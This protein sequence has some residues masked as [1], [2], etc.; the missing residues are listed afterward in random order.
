[1]DRLEVVDVVGSLCRNNDNCQT[2]ELPVTELELLLVIPTTLGPWIFQWAISTM[3]SCVRQKFCF[4]R[5]GQARLIRR[6][7]KPEDYLA[8]LY[9]FD[10]EK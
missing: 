3:P 7:E 9:G 4:K 10:I 5:D 2:K 1:M 6:A 8:T